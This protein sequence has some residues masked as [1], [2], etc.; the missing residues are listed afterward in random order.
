MS[1]SRC[2]DKEDIPH[3][4]TY[5]H[6]QEYYSVIKENEI[7]PLAITWMDFES[8]ILSEIKSEKDK[9][10]MLSLTCEI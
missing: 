5:T 9:Y 1:L 10:C 4:H 8:I 3:V 2:I 7:L 6:T